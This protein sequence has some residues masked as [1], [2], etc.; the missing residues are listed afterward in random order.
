MRVFHPHSLLISG[1]LEAL[2]SEA[3]AEEKV[4]RTEKVRLDLHY[5]DCMK[6]SVHER[7]YHPFSIA[8]FNNVD[9]SACML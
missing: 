5:G 4:R 2:Y 7:R 8:I 1:Q 6:A 9:L 3:C